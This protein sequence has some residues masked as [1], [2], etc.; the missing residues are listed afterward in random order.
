MTQFKVG[1]RVQTVKWKHPYMA[2]DGEKGVI[3]SAYVPGNMY[4][5]GVVLVKFGDGHTLGFHEHEIQIVDE[6]RKILI[7]HKDNITTARLLDGKKTIKS[8]EAKCAAGDTFN[9]DVGAALAFD[10]L[11]GREKAVEPEGWYGEAICTADGSGFTVGKKYTFIN[12]VVRDDDGDYRPCGGNEHLQS[13]SEN[14]FANKFI[15]YMGEA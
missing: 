8:A 9:F 15:E 5:R 3:V 6:P 2:I 14:W 4:N 10:R 12:G 7:T 1:D 11:I 13:T